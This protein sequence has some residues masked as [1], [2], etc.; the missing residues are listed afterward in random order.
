MDETAAR[1]RAPPQCG[2]DAREFALEGSTKHSMSAT[3]ASRSCSRGGLDLLKP[4]EASNNSCRASIC[5]YSGFLNFTQLVQRPSVWYVPFAHV[6]TTPSRSSAHA[7]PRPLR[8][9]RKGRM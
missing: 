8:A 9:P 1:F 5:E 4:L 2:V 3:W 7:A 6:P